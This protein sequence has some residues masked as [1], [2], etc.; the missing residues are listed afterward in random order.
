MGCVEVGTVMVPVV[1]RHLSS[2]ISDASV[3]LDV[4]DVPVVAAELVWM[5]CICR[6]KLERKHRTQQQ[7]D[8][9]TRL[10]RRGRING[11]NDKKCANNAI[12]ASNNIT[13]SNEWQ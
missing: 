7:T 11:S 2:R 8:S 9:K 1:H 3:H 10:G 12:I 4:V 13:K 5:K 6:A